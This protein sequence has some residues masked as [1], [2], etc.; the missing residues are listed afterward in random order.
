MDERRTFSPTFRREFKKLFA[1]H[2]C[3]LTLVHPR[4]MVPTYE[5]AIQPLRSKTGVFMQSMFLQVLIATAVVGQGA[6]AVAARKGSQAVTKKGS[7]AVAKNCSTKPEE[8]L[9]WY[10]S[11][12]DGV[13]LSGVNEMAQT[14]AL[15][16]DGLEDPTEELAN[17]CHFPQ[18]TT[19]YIYSDR[20]CD[21]HIKALSQLPNLM[22]LGI[23]SNCVKNL[24]AGSLKEAVPKLTKLNFVTDSLKLSGRELPSTLEDLSIKVHVRR[25]S[26]ADLREESADDKERTG[27]E[28]EE[29]EDDQADQPE[30]V[31]TPV[32]VRQV[33]DLSFLRSVPRL[34]K[35]W[36]FDINI[37]DVSPIGTLNKLENLTMFGVEMTQAK[38]EELAR[39][40]NIRNLKR[41]AASRL[42]GIKNL[43]PLK[44]LQ[45]EDTFFR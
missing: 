12:T 1:N 5:V 43:G 38:L 39:L 44:S 41:L 40:K 20:F 14:E 17:L 11:A 19:V 13:K 31:D 6:H 21:S 10:N 27:E 9:E 16:I 22:D 2:F 15:Q 35:L 37:K 34:T 4:R 32:R 23:D 30:P 26:A 8:A 18:V 25:V 28:G 45:L 7:Q 24:G 36:M 42:V 33:V 29:G 3:L